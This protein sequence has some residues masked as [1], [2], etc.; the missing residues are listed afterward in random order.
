MVNV[1][2]ALAIVVVGRE[3]WWKGTVGS[4]RSAAT[5]TLV[6][7]CLFR[8]ASR[9]REFMTIPRLQVVSVF[10][11]YSQARPR[12]KDISQPYL[13]S[14]PSLLLLQSVHCIGSL[15]KGR[16][17]SVKKPDDPPS[18][19][20]SLHH[21]H[22]CSRLHLTYVRLEHIFRVKSVTLGSGSE[23]SLPFRASFGI[24]VTKCTRGGSSPARAIHCEGL[25]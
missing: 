9:R 4:R 15:A 5:E 14:L 3:S 17:A 8:S 2:P 24:R 7:V 16:K 22:P 11:Q 18:Y 13:V 10:S 20:P 21:E 6:R 1:R 12:Y 23:S 19:P 25:G